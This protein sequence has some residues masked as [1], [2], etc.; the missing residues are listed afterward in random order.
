LKNLI[1]TSDLS[2]IQIESIL[3]K[4]KACKFN[5]LINNSNKNQR[6]IIIS[7]FFENSTRTRTSFDIA[8]Q[9]IGAKI[10]H[11]DVLRSSI[12]KGETIEDTILNISSMNPDLLII[13]HESN[14]FPKKI[15]SII[16]TPIINAGDG[17]NLH[18]TQALID[19]YTIIDEYGIDNLNGKVVSII[20]DISNS[21][22]ANSNI[23][24]L[25][26]FGMKVILV[27]PKEFIGKIKY[28]N[29]EIIE[30][31]EKAIDKSNILIRLRTQTERSNDYNEKFLEKYAKDYCITEKLIKDKNLIILHPGPVHR[32]IDISDNVLK[33]KRCKVLNQVENGI[34]I[35]MAILD[36]ILNG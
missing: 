4:A 32:N 19:L 25:K 35:R 23:E 7:L 22:V 36:L 2:D 12:N 9:K 11:L 21:R 20:G 16:N 34:Y 10:I 27:C 14:G 26:R 6:K 18:P 13:R 28:S 30:D 8:V 1:S 33:D 24:L 31:I 3:S 29:L 17:S 15:S 5:S